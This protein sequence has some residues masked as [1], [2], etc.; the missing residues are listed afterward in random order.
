MATSMCSRVRT[1]MVWAR[2]ARASQGQE[3]MP[4]TKARVKMLRLSSATLSR[5]TT[6]ITGMTRK[7]L[8]T[9]ERMLSTS[10]PLK[11]AMSPMTSP[12]TVAMVPAIRPTI[13]EVRVP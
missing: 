1:L 11:P 6:M 5:M 12:I 4:I 9:L 10:P 8:V 7:M 2:T 3:Q 13:S